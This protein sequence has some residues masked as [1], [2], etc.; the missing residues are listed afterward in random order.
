MQT[1][2]IAGG[3]IAGLTCAINLADR[4]IPVEVHEAKRYCGK[5]IRDIE[6]LENWSLGEDALDTLRRCGL[7]PTFDHHAVYSFKAYSPSLREVIVSARSPLMYRVWRGPVPGSIDESLER[8][9][10]DRGVS[11]RFSSK[12]REAEATVIAWGPRRPNILI[13]GIEFHTSASDRIEVLTDDTCAPGFYAYRILESGRGIIVTA[14]PAKRE[15][16][17]HLLERTIRRFQGIQAVPMAG[18]RRFGYSGALRVP[19]TAVRAGRL[20]VGEAAGFQ[21]CLFGFGMRYAMLS[22]HLAARALAEGEDY[23]RLW[24][25]AFGHQL[26]VGN[27][28]RRL[29]G[30]F[31]NPGYEAMI[32]ILASRNP[33]VA[34]LRRGGDVREFLSHVYTRRMPGIFRVGACLARMVAG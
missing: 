12:L 1:I 25:E 33:L 2:R 23:D 5:S 14:Y 34:A 30:L 24:R 6:Y 4:G 27:R 17:R 11:I 26:S 21:D 28:N 31:G 22:G 16:G 32:R 29:Y 3:G 7:D 19:T 15:H 18:V 9:A 13:A 10:K 20:Y 8:Q